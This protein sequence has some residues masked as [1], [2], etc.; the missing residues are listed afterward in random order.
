MTRYWA[1]ALAIALVAIAILATLLAIGGLSA[2]EPD[3]VVGV[4]WRCT[5][6][7]NGKSEDLRGAEACLAG[8]KGGLSDRYLYPEPSKASLH[9]RRQE[10]TIRT[11]DGKTYSV[12]VPPDSKSKQCDECQWMAL[13]DEWPPR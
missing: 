3:R 13:G 1:G 6:F 10:L 8:E 12:N 2:L 4:E 7:S 11:A 9:N 5:Y